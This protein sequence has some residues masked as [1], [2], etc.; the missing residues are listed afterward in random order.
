MQILRVVDLGQPADRV[1][2]GQDPRFDLGG[3]DLK[4]SGER[5]AALPGEVVDLHPA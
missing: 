2:A 1:D 4:A 3:P 5:R